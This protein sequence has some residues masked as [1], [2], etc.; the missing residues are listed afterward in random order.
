MHRLQTLQWC[1]LFG[2]NALHL[3]QILLPFC[4]D[5]TV[6]R[7]PDWTEAEC[8]EAAAVVAAAAATTA[9]PPVAT[10]AAPAATTAAAEI[11]LFVLFNPFLPFA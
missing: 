9:T 11:A 4:K 5:C 6:G 2:L 1:A 8:I 3:R 7:F 10:V